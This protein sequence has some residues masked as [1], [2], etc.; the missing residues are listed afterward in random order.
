VTVRAFV[1]SYSCVDLGS[2][3]RRLKVDLDTVCNE[4]FASA[5]KVNTIV[6][7]ICAPVALQLVIWLWGSG[8][9]IWN[10]W[11]RGALAMV[12]DGYKPEFFW[13]ESVGWLYIGILIFTTDAADLL[14]RAANMVGITVAFL[15]LTAVVRPFEP[16]E[17]NAL[18]KFNLGALGG[19]V[20]IIIGGAL[21]LQEYDPGL[22]RA[23]QANFNSSASARPLTVF[24]GFCVVVWN[25]NVLCDALASCWTNTISLQLQVTLDDGGVLSPALHR[26]HYMIYRVRGLNPVIVHV[27]N[28]QPGSRC[29]IDASKLTS[30]EK[31]L[32]AA[33]L[34]D[35]LSAC[36]D[37][38]AILGSQLVEKCIRE[39]ALRAEHARKSLLHRTQEKYGTIT[40]RVAGMP[41]FQ[42]TLR[43]PDIE[44]EEDPDSDEE[45]EHGSLRI[46]VTIDE[47][48]AALRDVNTDVLDHNNGMHRK[49]VIA[50]EQDHHFHRGHS[51][52]P[53]LL[54]WSQTTSF[55]SFFESAAG[56]DED[57]WHFEEDELGEEDP[58]FFKDLEVEMK[59]LKEQNLKM[60][61]KEL[62]EY[63]SLE[64]EI[65]DLRQKLG[66]DDEMI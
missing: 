59:R 55:K 9:E 51:A 66:D 7:V 39:A 11:F 33:D 6:M 21:T 25:V 45:L 62:A 28:T 47:L 35:T 36:I 41:C 18:A 17:R 24:Y 48:Q 12:V 56:D 31:T 2:L 32:L 30:R 42:A 44:I 20:L 53:Q 46:Q 40:H 3:G 16:Y 60:K 23:A 22:E 57:D 54:A 1:R 13:W 65:A 8:R 27:D 58:A 43:N 26:V 34:K 37:S 14:T 52:A 5:M 63:K 61:R 10:K 19:I 50:V 64:A 4:A 38:T 49:E 15:T 29:Y